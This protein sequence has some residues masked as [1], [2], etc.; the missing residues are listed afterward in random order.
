MNLDRQLD[1]VAVRGRE[2]AE[3]VF[4]HLHEVV[5][6]DVDSARKHARADGGK[7]LGFGQIEFRCS[8]LDGWYFGVDVMAAGHRSPQLSV[9][10]H[11]GLESRDTRIVV[12]EDYGQN[13][14]M[15]AARPALY[16]PQHCLLDVEGHERPMRL[17]QFSRL[18]L[19]PL[20]FPKG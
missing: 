1:W 2:H 19:E 10:R 12:R 17:W 4:R 5:K 14:A 13:G 18:A 6:R 3:E 11:F 9:Q 16:A 7:L 20:F 8:D 15:H